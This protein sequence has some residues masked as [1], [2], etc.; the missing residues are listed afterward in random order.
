METAG[1]TLCFSERSR[2]FPAL[3]A[4]VEGNVEADC[5]KISQAHETLNAGQRNAS[6][7]SPDKR[8]P[9]RFHVLERHEA[10]LCMFAKTLSLECTI[11]G[12]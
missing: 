7:W 12:V 3:H 4:R 9:E 6:G 5:L 8:R 11:N 2:Y 1:D 10:G